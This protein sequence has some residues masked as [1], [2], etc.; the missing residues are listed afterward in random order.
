MG[1]LAY[2]W[3]RH[4]SQS[5]RVTWSPGHKA[6]L[7]LDMCARNILSGQPWHSGKHKSFLVA[8]AEEVLLEGIHSTQVDVT[9]EVTMPGSLVH[10]YSNKL[11]SDDWLIFESITTHKDQAALPSDLPSL[12]QWHL[13]QDSA[14][15]PKSCQRKADH[16]T[17]YTIDNKLL[18]TSHTSVHWRLNH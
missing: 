1:L 12:K 3:L 18:E 5:H 14:H 4:W 17:S 7:A 15:K 11:F 2:L 16:E 6:V 8:R 10:T 13:T 9:W